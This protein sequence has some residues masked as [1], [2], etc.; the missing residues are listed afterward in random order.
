MH[1]ER[2]ALWLQQTG[3]IRDNLRYKYTVTINHVMAATI[4]FRSEDFNLTK[5][6]VE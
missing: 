4:D 1:E 5:N 6:S 2:T 3:H